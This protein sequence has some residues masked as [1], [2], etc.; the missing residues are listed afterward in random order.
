MRLPSMIV[1]LVATPGVATAQ[2]AQASADVECLR[3]AWSSL[4]LSPAVRVGDQVL[5]SR[6]IGQDATSKIPDRRESQARLAIDNVARTVRRAG[7]EMDNID[8]C[9]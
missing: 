1:A 5:L 2:P 9:S 3:D 4:P 8:K 7:L 6:Q